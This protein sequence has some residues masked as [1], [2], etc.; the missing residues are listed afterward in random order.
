MES[1]GDGSQFCVSFCCYIVAENSEKVR[2]SNICQAVSRLKN[3]SIPCNEVIG[4]VQAT[5]TPINYFITHYNILKTVKHLNIASAS[6]CLLYSL[7]PYKQH[8]SVLVRN[9]IRKCLGLVKNLTKRF[10]IQV[11]FYYCPSEMNPSDLNSKIPANLDVIE[12]CNSEFW[13]P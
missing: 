1:L 13:K 4:F 9:G 12:I 5:E 10:D 6:K 8:T 2:N 11:N 3:H 7:P